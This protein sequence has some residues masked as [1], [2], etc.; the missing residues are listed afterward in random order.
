MKVALGEGNVEEFDNNVEKFVKSFYVK[1]PNFDPTNYVHVPLNKTLFEHFDTY[2]TSNSE[3]IDDNY[4]SYLYSQYKLYGTRGPTNWY[5][6]SYLNGLNDKQK[7]HLNVE[8]KSLQILGARDFCTA[9]KDA[10][11]NYLKDASMVILEGG[12]WIHYFDY[13][14]VNTLIENFLKEFK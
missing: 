12:H 14:N 10:A 13:V 3:Y 2:D 1:K 5:R 6:T 7:P 11:Q 9:F 8:V 4:L